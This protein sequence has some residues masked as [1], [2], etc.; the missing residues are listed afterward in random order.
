MN[1]EQHNTLGVLVYSFVYPTKK[2]LEGKPPKTLNYLLELKRVGS[3]I[4]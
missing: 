1:H 3:M 2:D 4:S